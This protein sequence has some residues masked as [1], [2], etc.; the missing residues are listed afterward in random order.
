MRKGCKRS[1]SRPNKKVKVEEIAF[2]TGSVWSSL[3]TCMHVFFA[4]NATI[5]KCDVWFDQRPVKWRHKGF[6][7]HV[8]CIFQIYT[9]I[10][11]MWIQ[12]RSFWFLIT[13]FKA[14]ALL[15]LVVSGEVFNWTL[16]PFVFLCS[17]RHEAAYRGSEIV[18]VT[19]LPCPP[20]VS[21]T[22]FRLEVV[23][24]A[25][26]VSYLMDQDLPST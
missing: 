12:V 15:S 2:H 1:T 5:L 20:A 16:W 11:C 8:L 21:L 10:L 13:I 24:H 9:P 6:D 17:V 7:S 4:L 25:K 19:R 3:V 23:V 18:F 22:T 14:K 26:S